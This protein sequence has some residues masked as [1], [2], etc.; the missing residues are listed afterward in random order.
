[1]NNKK[2]TI[3]RR[4]FLK[5]SALTGGGLLIGFNFFTACKPEVKP[6]ID[7]SKLNFNEF[8]GFIKIAD[9]FCSD[10]LDKHLGN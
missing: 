10:C 1:M 7:I 6:P 8:N 4:S 9:K 5:A 2:T 3:D